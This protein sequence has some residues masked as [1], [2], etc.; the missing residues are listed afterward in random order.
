MLLLFLSKYGD[1]EYDDENSEDYY[2]YTPFMFSFDVLILQ[3]ILQPI[4]F[5][6]TYLICYQSDLLNRS[7]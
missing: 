1:W 3:W 6:V 7:L 4:A 5:V 2:A